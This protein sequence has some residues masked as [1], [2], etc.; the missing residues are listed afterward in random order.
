M[1]GKGSR[2]DLTSLSS[3]SLA[4]PT[5][6]TKRLMKGGIAHTGLWDTARC[7]YNEGLQ[8]RPLTPLSLVVSP[9]P[10]GASLP[11][12]AWLYPFVSK[13]LVP[14]CP[15]STLSLTALHP[16]FGPPLFLPPIPSVHSAGIS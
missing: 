16:C 4:Q 5:V 3:C 15:D 2:S 11:L 8:Q 14:S 7:L 13:P 12:L 9:L 6:A 10:P 1:S